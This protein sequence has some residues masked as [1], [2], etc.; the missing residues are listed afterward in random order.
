MPEAKDNTGKRFG[1]WTAL[2]RM[3]DRIDKSGYHHTIWKCK[4]D[5]GTIRDVAASGLYSGRSTSCGCFQ[6]EKASK[7]ASVVHI[8]HGGSKERLYTIWNDMKR[9]C[10]DKNRKNYCDYGGRG[11]SVC[12]EWFDFMTFKTWALNN[13]Y[14]D[15][16]S[17][18]R[19]NND[20]NY[21]PDNC[22]WV[23]RYAQANNRRSNIRIIH[24]NEEK[25][26]AEWAKC[27]DISYAELQKLY[28]MYEI[29]FDMCIDRLLKLKNK[30]NP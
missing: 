3:P 26:L 21:E 5:C 28:S 14:N 18:D 2:Y 22:R 9:R 11:I 19:I 29:P 15:T 24:N 12:P 25:T 7:V 8:T 13:G 1:R 20:G 16:L 17:I 10:T 4:C 27:Y 23:D 30:K 6:K